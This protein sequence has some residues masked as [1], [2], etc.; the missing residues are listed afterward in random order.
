MTVEMTSWKWHLGQFSLA[1]GRM[2]WNEERTAWGSPVPSL[3][4]RQRVVRP[5]LSPHPH[6]GHTQKRDG[7]EDGKKQP[8]G[9]GALSAKEWEEMSPR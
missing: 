6:P 9:I 3:K 1:E 2:G 5:T 8:A 7:R 4:S